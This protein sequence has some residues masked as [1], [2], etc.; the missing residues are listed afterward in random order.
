MA[1][2]DNPAPAVSHPAVLRQQVAQRLVGRFK[3][4]PLSWGEADCALMLK[5]TCMGLGLANPL[6]GTKTYA[7]EV[8]AVRALRAAELAAGL[9]PGAGLA[10]LLDAKG[11][12]RIP[13]ASA[14]PCDLIGLPG[15]D[16]WGIAIGI[17]L[18]D[19][20]SLAFTPNVEGREIC[21]V[22]DLA[23]VAALT[24]PDTGNRVVIPAWRLPVCPP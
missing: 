3:G 13:A 14:L 18:G 20:R 23:P 4:K 8:G 7:T 24:H 12:E 17:A 16:P 10:A 6:K 5:V 19:G 11:W 21:L 9:E 1:H 2:G 15:P 22:G